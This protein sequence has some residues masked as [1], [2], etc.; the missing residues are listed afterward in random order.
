MAN[1]RYYVYLSSFFD[2]VKV[3]RLKL[4]NCLLNL[5]TFPWGLHERRSSL[6]TALVRRQIDDSDYVIVLLGGKYGDLSAS[7]LSYLHLDFLYA[8]NKQKIMISLVDMFPDKRSNQEQDQHPELIKKLDH[9][10]QLLKKDSQ[11]YYE[12]KSTLDL[13][14]SMR[15]IFAQVVQTHPASGWIKLNEHEAQDQASHINTSKFITTA[16]KKLPERHTVLDTLE[17]KVSGDENVIVRYHAHAY[18]DGN[19]QDI[20]PQRHLGWFQI[21]QILSTHFQ[22]PALENNFARALNQY[23]ESTAL[24]DA[25]QIFPRAHAVARTQIDEQ[26][27]QEIKL[28]MKWN[29]WIVP[30]AQHQAGA[31]TYWELTMEAKKLLQVM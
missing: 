28:Q 13:E 21:L 8:L 24:S 18:Q 17:T 12:F 31:R 16:V 19:L 14:S 27:L 11:Y 6:N 4:E 5:D 22:T 30:L 1:K 9:F 15:R 10:R 20:R 7:G 2:D 29:N 23:L 26:C 3:E 25:R